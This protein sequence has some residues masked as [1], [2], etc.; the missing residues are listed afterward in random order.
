MACSGIITA[1]SFLIILIIVFFI[2]LLIILP[3][4]YKKSRGYVERFKNM[5]NTFDDINLVDNKNNYHNDSYFFTNESINEIDNTS[6][7]TVNELNNKYKYTPEKVLKN[8]YLLKDVRNN[9]EFRDLHPIIDEYF[10][11]YT[12]DSNNEIN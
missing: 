2:H 10:D 11:K 5:D 1:T 9:K 4:L 3:F 12:K 8:L 7:E 6:V